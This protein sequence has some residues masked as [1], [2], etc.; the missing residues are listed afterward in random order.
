MKPVLPV[1]AEHLR[2]LVACDHLLIFR[3]TN[4]CLCVDVC[5]LALVEDINHSYPEAGGLI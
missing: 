1:F 3:V 4:V 2:P 5:C